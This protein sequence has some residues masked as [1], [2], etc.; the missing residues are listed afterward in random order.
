[1][2]S[3]SLEAFKGMASSAVPPG[4]IEMSGSVGNE[5]NDLHEAACAQTF[6]ESLKKLDLWFHMDREGIGDDR[7]FVMN[8]DEDCIRITPSASKDSLP[9]PCTESK[10]NDSLTS[11]HPSEWLK[12]LVYPV[13]SKDG[14][15]SIV[16]VSVRGGLESALLIEAKKLREKANEDVYL[17]HLTEWLCYPA[18]STNL[19]ILRYYEHGSLENLLKKLEPVPM[20]RVHIARVMNGVATAIHYLHTKKI[21]HWSIRPSHILIDD[22]FYGRLTGLSSAWEIG[23]TNTQHRHQVRTNV[24]DVF[25]APESGDKN[26]DPLPQDMFA[27]GVILCR[28]LTGYLPKRNGINVDYE[29]IKSVCHTPV[30]PQVWKSVQLL[31]SSRLDLR[32]T[33]GAFLHCD[34]MEEARN[35]PIKQLF[36]F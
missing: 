2:E 36:F 19:L 29:Y 11:I 23:D 9:T 6:V 16:K 7:S 5:Q 13:Y 22:Q 18:S 34:W 26:A 33:A 32:P 28:C 1:M 31:M 35:N 25:R 15:R 12:G 14:V 21:A 30:D 3:D 4:M 8:I 20:H 24:E 17:P 10:S 27:I